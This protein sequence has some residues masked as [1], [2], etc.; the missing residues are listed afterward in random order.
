MQQSSR[1]SLVILNGNKLVST[2]SGLKIDRELIEV[3]TAPDGLLGHPS[4]DT[5]P[6]TRLFLRVIQSVTCTLILAPWLSADSNTS[7]RGILDLPIHFL[8][9]H[10]WYTRATVVGINQ[11]GVYLSALAL[12]WPLFQN[13]AAL[14][15]R[16]E[17]F[18]FWMNLSLS[19]VLSVWYWIPAILGL[20]LVSPFLVAWRRGLPAGTTRVTPSHRERSFLRSDFK[21]SPS[22]LAGVSQ[23]SI[24][25]DRA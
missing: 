22:W 8:T 19:I 6:W 4:D 5:R 3:G 2:Q 11:T 21:L 15:P 25:S 1:R 18:E 9:I 14:K 17:Q 23:L 20:R 12:I 10:Y 16:G 24:S 13:F 7:A